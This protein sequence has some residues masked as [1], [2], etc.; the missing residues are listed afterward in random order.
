LGKLEY[1]ISPRGSYRCLKPSLKLS[2]THIRQAIE[3]HLHESDD[4]YTHAFASLPTITVTLFELLKLMMEQTSGFYARAL[5]VIGQDLAGLFP[6]NLAIELDGNKFVAN[7]LCAKSRITGQN[8][9]TAWMGVKKLIDKVSDIV[10]VPNHEPDLEFVPFSRVYNVND[11]DRL[12]E[13]GTN[14]RGN[15]T[16]MPD[17]YSLGERLRTIGKVIDA[18]NGRVV[19]IFKD[20]HQIMFE[21]QDSDGKARKEELSNTELYQLQ[22]RY[23]SGRSAAGTPKTSEK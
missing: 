12:D 1:L 22:Q 11:I 14:Y 18:Q 23:A 6:E 7:G 19:K 21:Y 15:D 10:R 20:L 3:A 2:I 17:I 16:G 8:P 5:R 9:T 13:Q 4:V